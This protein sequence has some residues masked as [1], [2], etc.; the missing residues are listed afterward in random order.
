MITGLQPNRM[1]NGKNRPRDATGQQQP[2][3]DVYNFI[4][5]QDDDNTNPEYCGP[6]P[7]KTFTYAEDMNAMSRLCMGVH[8]EFD[9]T[10]GS[11]MGE[12]VGNVIFNTALRP[13]N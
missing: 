6:T 8:W 11:K 9:A 2:N 12:E 3:I 7:F 13:A 10:Y 5:C 4:R 1:F